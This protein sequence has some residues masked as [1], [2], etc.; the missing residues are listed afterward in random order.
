MPLTLIFHLSEDDVHRL[1]DLLVRCP[2]QWAQNLLEQVSR[3]RQR[4]YTVMLC[5]WCHEQIGCDTGYGYRHVKG[6]IA[7]D[8][9]DTPDQEYHTAERDIEGEVF[10]AGGRD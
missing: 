2:E 3:A 1:Q 8:P 5:R 9:A 10:N 6:N 4:N 7:C